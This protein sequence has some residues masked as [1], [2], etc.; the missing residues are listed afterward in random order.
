MLSPHHW[1]TRFWRLKQP[2]L[3]DP[4]HETNPIVEFHPA[5]SGS[6]NV[7]RDEIQKRKMVVHFKGCREAKNLFYRVE[8]GYNEGKFFAVLRKGGIAV[9]PD[10]VVVKSAGL[11]ED[12]PVDVYFRLAREVCM[13]MQHNETLGL[14]P[15]KFAHW[16]NP[17]YE[18][19]GGAPYCGGEGS[20]KR[21]SPPDGDSGEGT[22]KARRASGAGGGDGVGVGGSSSRGAFDFSDEESDC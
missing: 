17:G 16:F 13:R 10:D 7:S 3:E 4:V 6:L 19:G 22:K 11:G 9:A 18:G 21:S 15:K 2:L 14:G 8:K 20:R 1:P 5:N 12:T